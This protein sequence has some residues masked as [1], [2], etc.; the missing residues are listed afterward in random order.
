MLEKRRVLKKGRIV[1]TRNGKFVIKLANKIVRKLKPH[2]R[3]I[4]IVG[5]IR[6]NEKNP[7]D[8][9]IVLIPKD[10]RKIEKILGEKGKFVQG[11]EKR[12][13]FK[14]QGV[15][16]ELYYTDSEEWGAALLAYSSKFGAGI[17]LRIVARLKGFK[18][19]QHG[20][21]KRKTGKKVAGKSEEEIYS[22]LG[23]KWKKPE[24]R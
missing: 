7:T 19:N 18:L 9:D 1:F 24:E 20:L 2:S 14:I 11:G 13:T 15:K 5:S 16:V 3:R 12:A 17:G 6:R 21:F 10:K 23:R 4:Q 8:I 22:A